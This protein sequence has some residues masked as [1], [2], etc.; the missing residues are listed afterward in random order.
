M[1]YLRDD[2]IL[3]NWSWTLN[4]TP[5]F[6]QTAIKLALLLSVEKL[7]RSISQPH[8]I[9]QKSFNMENC[10]ETANLPKLIKCLVL[11]SNIIESETKHFQFP[12]PPFFW[13]ALYIY[14]NIK[15]KREL[16]SLIWYIYFLVWNC[17]SIWKEF[18]NK[19][20]VDEN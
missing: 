19:Y 10:A 17:Y 8:R 11:L 13:E 4:V 20:F 9:S 5:I 15:L 12:Y 18:I 3:N 16:K 14:I 2:F 1:Q 6:D 7:L